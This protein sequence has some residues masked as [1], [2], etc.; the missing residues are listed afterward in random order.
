[1]A[2]VGVGQDFKEL[3]EEELSPYV[4]AV[5]VLWVCWTNRTITPPECPSSRLPCTPAHKNRRSSSPCGDAHTER[6]PPVLA[7]PVLLNS[8][9]CP[10]LQFRVNIRNKLSV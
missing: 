7:P 3:S 9:T 10:A 1:M 6:T 5:A 2:V 4:E 8:N